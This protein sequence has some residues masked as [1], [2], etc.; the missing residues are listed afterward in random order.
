MNDPYPNLPSHNTKDHF[1][2]RIGGPY[3][4]NGAGLRFRHRFGFGLMDASAAVTMAESWRNVPPAVSFNS[5]SLSGVC[6]LFSGKRADDSAQLC[7][8]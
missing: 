1:E 4:Q 7:Y 6:A 2:Q 5:G 8:E 3:V